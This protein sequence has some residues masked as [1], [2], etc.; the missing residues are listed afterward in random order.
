MARGGKR[1]GA[2]RPK[3]TTGA[4]KDVVKKMYSFR[5]SEEEKKAVKELLA[6]MRGKLVLLLTLML[7][8]L[9]AFCAVESTPTISHKNWKGYGVAQYGTRDDNEYSSHKYKYER[10]TKGSKEFYLR[11]AALLSRPCRDMQGNG[12]VYEEPNCRI[13][14][15]GT[16]WNDITGWAVEDYGT[17]VEYD[18]RWTLEILRK[19]VYALDNQNRITKYKIT[20]TK[21]KNPIKNFWFGKFDVY[22]PVSYFVQTKVGEKPK[23][24]GFTYDK[25]GKLISMGEKQTKFSEIVEYDV[26]GN[27]L[28]VYRK[29]EQDYINEFEPDG[30]TLRT[31]HVTKYL[32]YLQ[33]EE[34][35][36]RI[37]KTIDEFQA[38][39]FDR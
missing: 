26:N 21:H 23:K 35:E 15:N 18:T 19:Y 14:E 2:G 24:Q 3:G 7:L 10:R 39:L 30:K 37:Y 28:S 29:N 25:N 20:E 4:Y 31:Y 32:P 27:V 13:K 5:L 34:D 33:W 22:T 11:N 38:K 17:I 9:P 1:E 16:Y 12:V 6:K 36:K 8:G